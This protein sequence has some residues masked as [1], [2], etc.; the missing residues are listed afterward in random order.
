MAFVR[1]FKGDALRSM[2]VGIPSTLWG[3][4][5]AGIY[6]MNIDSNNNDEKFLVQRR[7]LVGM[8]PAL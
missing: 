5:R 3:K 1:A 6:G 4:C 2:V 7:V 8:N